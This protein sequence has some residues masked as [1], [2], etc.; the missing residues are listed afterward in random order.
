MRLLVIRHAEPELMSGPDPPLTARGREQA[1]RLADAL[2]GTMLERVVCSTMHRAVQT[3]EPLAKALGVPLSQEPALVEIDLGTLWHPSQQQAWDE[4]CARWRAGDHAA[5]CPQGESLFD[6][7]TRVQPVAARLLAEP[8]CRSIAVIAH[9]VV[10]GVLLPLLCPELRPKL[11][12]YLN[13]SYAGVWELEGDSA[14]LRV[15]RQDD[16]SHL[17]L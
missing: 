13:H 12:H 8:C 5:R 4:I 15:V 16:T 1:V 3:A 14:A 17:R 2:R 10:N 9:A 11:G 6:V 7:V